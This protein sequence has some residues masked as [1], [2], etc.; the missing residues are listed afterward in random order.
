M[1]RECRRVPA[2]WV[3]PQRADGREG[4]QPM[5]DWSFKE[6]A[7]NWLANCVL[8]SK[9]EHEDQ[10]SHP[11]Y[12]AKYPYYWQWSGPPPDEEWHRPDW[13]NEIRTH[14]QMYEDTSEGTPISPVFAT[15]E[16]VAS[17][18]VD[19]RASAFGRETATYEWWLA[20]AKGAWAPDMIRDSTGLHTADQ[21]TPTMPPSATG[22]EG[23]G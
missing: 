10:L 14:Y 8:W 12:R 3:H 15:P 5:F 23:E 16:E 1:G 20:I 2:D 6:Q 7:D 4:Y 17:W 9:G 22:G 21:L 11:E 18:C 19:N 13:P